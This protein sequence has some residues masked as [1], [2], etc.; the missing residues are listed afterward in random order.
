MDSIQ[1]GIQRDRTPR[2]SY[3]K[4]NKDK[5]S[6]NSADVHKIQP[7]TRGQK[8]ETAKKQL[9]QK[10][11]QHYQIFKEKCNSAVKSQR[12]N[13]YYDGHTNKALAFW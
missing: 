5:L 10:H 13:N 2:I 9:M 4:Q 1:P 7:V 11:T 8:V 12:S 3:F 6:I